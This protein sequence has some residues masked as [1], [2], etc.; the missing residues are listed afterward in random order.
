VATHGAGDS[1]QD[2][3]VMTSQPVIRRF[4][5]VLVA[6]AAATAM[7]GALARPTHYQC[8]GYKP[9]DVDFSPLVAQVRFEDQ[10]YTLKRVRDGGEAR[11]VGGRGVDMTLTMRQSAM[12]LKVKGET[13]Q[14]KLISDALAKFAASAPE[15]TTASAR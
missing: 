8:T 12:E 10:H 14:C 1:C 6:L 9:M 13:L 11:F 4:L 2:R 3:H 5:P 7:T 15:P